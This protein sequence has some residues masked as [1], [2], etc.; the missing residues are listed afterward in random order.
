MTCNKPLAKVEARLGDGAYVTLER[1][2]AGTY[3]KAVSVPPG[4]PVTF[5]ATGTSGATATSVAYP[6]GASAP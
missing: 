1:T 3:A 5:R 2:A 6:W 4:T